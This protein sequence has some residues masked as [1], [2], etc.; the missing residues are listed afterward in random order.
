MHKTGLSVFEVKS[1]LLH[2]MVGFEVGLGS[3][4][5]EELTEGAVHDLPKTLDYVGL[6]LYMSLVLPDSNPKR[7][8]HVMS[9]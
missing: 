6:A 9:L 5:T 3:D 7:N 1:C 2:R 8:N 4:E